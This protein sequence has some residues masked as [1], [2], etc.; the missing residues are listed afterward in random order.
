MA[1]RARIILA[2]ASEDQPTKQQV[3]AQLGVSQATV[4]KWRRRFVA[5]RLDGLYDESR[6]GAPR[7][8]MDDDV[9]KVVVKTLEDKPVDATHWSTRSMAKAT[10]ISPTTVSRIWRAFPLTWIL[11]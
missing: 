5:S 1:L 4:G 10:G 6:P 9:E 3:A 2:C 8:V 11:E 7:T